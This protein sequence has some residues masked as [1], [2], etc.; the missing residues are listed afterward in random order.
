[1]RKVIPGALI[2]VCLLLVAAPVA[3]GQEPNDTLGQGPILPIGQALGGLT[4]YPPGDLDFFLLWGKPDRDFEITTSTGE[5]VDTRLQV[6]DQ[7]SSLVVQNDDYTH[8]N[9][10]SRAR[11]A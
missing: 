10:G 4:L 9:P 8:G 1:M 6:F 2:I 11:C 3:L 5:G 7:N